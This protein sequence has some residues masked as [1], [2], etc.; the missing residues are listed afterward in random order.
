[1]SYVAVCE[2]CASQLNF[3]ITIQLQIDGWMCLGYKDKACHNHKN[4]EWWK[5][6]GKTCKTFDLN[7]SIENKIV[8]D[9]QRNPS[10]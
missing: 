7:Y 10:T 1:M 4:C 6:L 8:S 5:V 9:L 3:K 2:G